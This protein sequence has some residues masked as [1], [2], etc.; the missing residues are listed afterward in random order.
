MALLGPHTVMIMGTGLKRRHILLLTIVSALSQDR[1]DALI[2]FHCLSGC[3][4][5][6][7][8][9]GKSKTAWWNSFLNAS[10]NVNLALTKLGVDIHPSDHVLMGCGEMIC[11]LL[12][13]KHEQHKTA[14]NLR[15]HH[16]CG[17]NQNHGIDKLPPTQGAMH[18]HI[19]R[20]HLQGHIWQ[21]T[22]IPLQRFLEPTELGWSRGS[23]GELKPILTRVPLVPKC[24]LQLVK[25]GCRKSMCKGNCSC[26]TN[27][28]QCTELCAC[29]ADILTNS[30]EEEHDV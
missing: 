4:T 2:G 19:R 17:Q 30:D 26:R 21:Q 12:S 20:A 15:W 29:E 28:V 3:D 18:E 16:F 23:N 22:L 1:V 11:S 13:T 5:T 24:V 8:L 25:C 6:G 14:E 27:N 7:H 9:F 10:K